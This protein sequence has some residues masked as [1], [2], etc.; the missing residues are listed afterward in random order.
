MHQLLST[1]RHIATNQSSFGAGEVIYGSFLE[2]V[3]RIEKL[4]ETHGG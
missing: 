4:L 3:E 1:V 2:K